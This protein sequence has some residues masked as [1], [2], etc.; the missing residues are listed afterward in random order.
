MKWNVSH[1]KETQDRREAGRR[2]G[3]EWEDEGVDDFSYEPVSESLDYD[4]DPEDIEFDPRQT[5]YYYNND[6]QETYTQDDEY[7]ADS[8]YEAGMEYA[9]EPDYALNHDYVDGDQVLT[10][11]Y[12]Q[13]YYDG[14]DQG[15]YQSVYYDG[16]GYDE[17]SYGEGDFVQNEFVGFD[18]GQGAYDQEVY[19]EVQAGRGAYDQEV[20]D[21]V[22]AG[23]GAY[24]QEVY[25]EVQAGRGAYDQEVYDEVQAGRGAYD[26]EVYDEVQADQGAYGQEFYDEVQADQGAYGQE[27]YDEV[28]ADRGAYGRQAYDD[29][30]YEE[31]TYGGRKSE[32]NE[33]SSR[34]KAGGAVA[35]AYLGD[36]TRTMTPSRGDREAY[37]QASRA[38]AGKDAGSTRT[39]AKRDDGFHG[40]ITF[41]DDYDQP[42][43]T[44]RESNASSASRSKKR[45]KNEESGFSPLDGLIAAVGIV[46]I[47]GLVGFIGWFYFSHKD[48]VNPQNQFADIGTQLQS[49]DIIGGKGI[50]AVA[51]AEMAKL[52]QIV[53][54]ETEVS[55]EPQESSEY[56]EKSYANTVAVA[57]S[58]TSV[59]KDLKIKF[60]NRETSKLVGNVRFV[61][62][63]TK[64]DGTTEEWVDS[65]MDGIIYEKGIEAGK[66]SV[67]IKALT[68]E[69][70]NNYILP[71][72][73][74]TI[75]VKKNIE[76]SK[77][78]VSGEGKKESEINTNKEDTKKNETTMEGALTD[79]V[80]WVAS[81]TTGNT[82]TEVLKSS[83]PDPLT[84][85]ITVAKSFMRTSMTD[86]TPE[87]FTVYFNANGGS[88]SMA[89]VEMEAGNYVL[90]ECG[91]TAPEGKEFNGWDKGSVGTT[92]QISGA[93]TITA[94]WKTKAV[95]TYSVSFS[96]NGGSGSMAS[97]TVEAGKEYTLPECGFTAPD[98][99]VFDKWDKGAAGT[100]ITINGNET[101]SAQWKDKPAT[102]YTIKFAAGEGGSGTMADVTASAGSYTLPECKFT[103]PQGKQFDKWDKGAA[104]SKIDLTGNLTL[105]AQWKAASSTTSV[106]LDVT[107]I[108]FVMK[109]AADGTAVSENGTAKATA[110]GFT[111]GKELKYE[112]SSADNAIATAAIDA[113]GK[114]TVIAVGKGTTKITVS[115]DYKNDADKVSGVTTKA[116][117]T[118]DI[119]VTEKDALAI[120]LDKTELLCYSEVADSALVV[121]VTIKNS[122]Q[123]AADLIESKMKFT[124]ESS[125]TAVATISKKEFI[126]S[127]TDGTVKVKLTMTAQTLTEKKSCVVTA[128]YEEGKE[129]VSAKCTIT[130]KPHPK[131]DKSTALVDK[132]GKQLFVQVNGDYRQAVYADYYV[133]GTK[134]FVQSGVKYTGWQTLNGK[135]YFFNAEG[136]YVTGEQVIQGAKYTFGSD[137]ALISGSAVLGID[138]SRW[139]G[140]I[141]WK[142]VKNSGVSFVIIRCGYR[143]STEGKLIEDSKFATNIK[144]ATNAGLKVGVYFFTQAVD[145]V[146]AVYEASYV[147]D[148][149]KNYKINYPVFLDVEASGGRADK[150]S[151][152]TRT[153]VCKAFCETIQSAGYTA[154]IYAN[155]NW[156]TEKLD[157]SQLS[158][159]KIW[160]AQYAAAPTYKGTYDMWQYKSTGSVGGISGD[161]DMDLSYMGY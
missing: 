105:T 133:E 85:P 60:S 78:D 46:V 62:E 14:Y 96:P 75:N 22:Q 4:T 33:R 128:K 131:Y 157:A 132:D 10:E 143:G 150:I 142:A 16:A 42:T 84:R 117:K 95:T 56:N 57:M 32:F 67:Y 61:A 15:E 28:Q 17:A 2:R 58:L 158:A 73:A 12:D 127:T 119:V 79:T 6:L 111:E 80:A 5:G 35:P 103:A 81:S 120:S 160:L 90:P 156:L 36:E 54:E 8:E 144:G 48:P 76:Y 102:S 124:A 72:T 50:A 155:K 118:I 83:I 109:K 97:V 49:I 159:Y 89:N 138:V 87:K 9:S 153:K 69:K 92:I 122:D 130:V 77:V 68:D 116:S 112:A 37:R 74:Q 64:P 27:F 24:D 99:K 55:P 30:A 39:R 121:E 70:Y 101:I 13:E 152:E 146:E 25:D 51:N 161:V 145:E 71:S 148:K 104:G 125:D 94:Q 114:I 108:E 19:D 149:I 45:K 98:G 53:P 151:V 110:K 154:G 113:S 147:I 38:T 44:A 18:A 63:I 88:G 29:L 7:V 20:Y 136:K 40:E 139:N 3:Y 129:S 106:E 31:D 21:E 140:T 59:Q 115:V 41:I 82:Y 52:V 137:G 134:F 135:V 1:A 86:Q 34:R 93:V 100:K 91:F 11:S 43:K 23:Q 65:D 126:P 123:K 141:D 66:Y 26:Q 107:K 47:V